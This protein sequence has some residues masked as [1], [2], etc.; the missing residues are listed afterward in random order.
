MESK[1]ISNIMLTILVMS[2]FA[3]TF[4]I[5]PVKTGGTICI[6][7][8][9]SIEPPT[10]PIQRD[11]NVY[12]F[13]NDIFD[14]TVV[15]E[16][17]NIVVDGSGYTLQGWGIGYGFYLDGINNVTIKGTN[18]KRFSRGI[19]LISSSFNTVSGNNITNNHIWGVGLYRSFNNTISGN[20]ITNNYMGAVEAP[21]AG[22][23]LY[24]SFN[25]TISGNYITNNY[26]GVDLGQSSFN[27]IT[28]NSIT[29]HGY[30]SV[31][32]SESSNNTV[33]RNDITNNSYSVWLS[34]SSNNT[35]SGN[36]ITNNSYGV[37]LYWSSNNNVVSGNDITNN[38]YGVGILGGIQ[39]KDGLRRLYL[40][41]NSTISGNNITNNHLG[42]SLYLSSN[43]IIYHNN[44]INNTQQV[45]DYSWDF[46]DFLPS[47]NSW[48][49]DY[50]SGG[51][52]WSDYAG[53]DL[54]SG[55]YQN[56]TGNDGIGDAPYDVDVNNQDNYPLMSIFSARAR[57]KIA[58]FPELF[59]DNEVR[60]ILPSDDPDKPLVLGPAMLTDWMASGI[61]FPRLGVVTEG[62]DTNPLFV[63]QNTGIPLGEPGIGIITFGGPDV[64]LVTLYAETQ[65]NAPIIFEIQDDAFFFKHYSGSSIPGADLPISVINFDEDMFVIEVFEDGYGRYFLICQGFGW[66]GTYAAGK[67]FDRV[68]YPNLEDH[69]K[70]WMIVKWDDTNGDGF[71]N[72]PGDGDTYTIIATG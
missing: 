29:N 72:A 30:R 9:G 23:G 28:G 57:V 44:F 40:S 26:V 46:P 22:V 69:T 48:D 51:N 56:D 66:K 50:P 2:I 34:R 47:I 4:N 7:P 65:G 58:D 10:A 8:D 5:Q 14:E 36:S 21:G 33:S 43:N 16:R 19:W 25:S 39:V 63:N 53:V 17:G 49:R 38:S 6:K 55:P 70:S 68:I 52:H 20:Y 24:R 41:S 35:V 1:T 45:Y 42:V 27:T 11:G 13:T 60:M 12:T 15:V 54:Y 62:V 67:Y 31:V 64:N 37:A 71:V 18:I 59:M 61:I 3:S 32:L